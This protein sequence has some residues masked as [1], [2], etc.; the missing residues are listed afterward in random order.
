MHVCRLL[1]FYYMY[2]YSYYYMYRVGKINDQIICFWEIL[3]R[4]IFEFIMS[5]SRQIW[6]HFRTL[7]RSTGDLCEI[8]KSLSQ[9]KS[10]FEKSLHD[11]YLISWEPM[12]N[13][14][15]IKEISLWFSFHGV[16]RNDLQCYTNTK[17]KENAYFKEENVFFFHLIKLKW[18]I[19][20][21][22]KKKRKRTRQHKIFFSY[23]VIHI[24]IFFSPPVFLTW[25]CGLFVQSPAI[26]LWRRTQLQR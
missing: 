26:S 2:A 10:R 15:D 19:P 12:R 25:L 21:V 1:F 7:L 22:Q 9:E 16:S 13:S 17:L 11:L 20:F 3:M 5:K 6:A 18:S 24:L 14:W 8:L 23:S 4:N